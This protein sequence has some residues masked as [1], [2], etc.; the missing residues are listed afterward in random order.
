[1]KHTIQLKA[2][3][4]DRVAVRNYRRSGLWEEGRL[5]RV[6]VCWWLSPIPSISYTVHLD[7]ASDAGN[8]IRLYVN[9]DAIRNM[10]ALDA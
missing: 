8:P 10:E 7:R 9:G 5:E 1:M 2:E 3:I 6:E 4:D